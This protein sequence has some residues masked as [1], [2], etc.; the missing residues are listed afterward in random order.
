ML[1]VEAA[2][3]LALLMP[4]L[5]FLILRATLDASSRTFVLGM[6]MCFVFEKVLR[7]IW[8]L[9]IDSWLHHRFG[10]D[11]PEQVPWAMI[12]AVIT[13]ALCIAGRMNASRVLLKDTTTL[14]AATFGA[15]WGALS[16]F[17][18][19]GVWVG[20]SLVV[21]LLRNTESLREQWTTTF[22]RLTPPVLTLLL[23]ELP[24]SLLADVALSLLVLQW[25]RG[26]GRQWLVATFLASS[27][28]AATIGALD[29]MHYLIEGRILG[30]AGA[31]ALFIWAFVAAWR[32]S[33]T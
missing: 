22:A 14:T 31:S 1:L 20:A 25:A 18:S 12:S 5:A 19:V 33:A 8:H 10:D 13:T 15:G 27:A 30:I 17:G 2:V 29:K 9:P 4:L 16:V 21:S 32:S 11:A 7:G 24:F 26:R 23:V 6:L 28:V 3:L